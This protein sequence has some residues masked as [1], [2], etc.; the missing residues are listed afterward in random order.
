M[1]KI[2]DK[3]SEKSQFPI[4]VI[5]SVPKIEITGNNTLY[6]ENHK[7]IKSLTSEQVIIKFEKALFIAEGEKISILEINKEYVYLTGFF[8]SFIFDK[9]LR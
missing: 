3:I 4:E 7:G 5:S 9:I 2:A 8:H 1:K 6:I